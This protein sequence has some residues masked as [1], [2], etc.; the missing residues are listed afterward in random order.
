M[1]ARIALGYP[2]VFELTS[3]LILLVALIVAVAWIGGRVYAGAIL[4]N[5]Q[6]NLLQMITTLGLR[7]PSA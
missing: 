6:V 4:T 3:A 5:R 1:P 2:S 7:R